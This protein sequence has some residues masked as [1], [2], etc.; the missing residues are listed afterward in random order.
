MVEL[1]NNKGV[2]VKLYLSEYT[3]EPHAYV[4]AD[5]EW[6]A[7][8]AYNQDYE[9]FESYLQ[10]IELE[11]NAIFIEFNQS[12]EFVTND[13]VFSELLK[14]AENLGFVFDFKNSH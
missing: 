1:K 8:N 10:S 5:W 12:E 2:R 4:T 3:Q 6:A 9:R 7:N 14:V 13:E 11:F